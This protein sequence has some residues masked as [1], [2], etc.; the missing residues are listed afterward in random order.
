MEL[1]AL[2]LLYLCVGCAAFFF[3]P[4]GLGGGLLFVP[5]LHYVA[6][7]EIG[8]VT[9][10]T[11]LILTAVVS[12]ASGYRHKKEGLW[13]PELTKSAL[14][15]AIPGAIIGAIIVS[16]IGDNLDLA[17]KL[18]SLL[19]IGYAIKRMRKRLKPNE[20]LDDNETELNN[21]MIGLGSSIGG[22]TSAFLAVGGG[23][24]YIPVLDKFSNASTREIVGS[25]YGIM[26]WTV[27]IVILT[28]ALLFSGPWHD[29]G[30][31]LTL[32]IIVFAMANFG[33]KFGL[34]LSD[35]TVIKVFLSI[36]LIVFI[37]YVIDLTSYLN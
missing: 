14:I 25:S 23:A 11:S 24:I 20:N 35:T 36:I 19:M 6:G 27:P 31:I 13:N 26:M 7:W 17:F 33:A 16:L 8:Q 3:A 18:V 12:W 32:P 22:M 37:R 2:V 15:G 10:L 30:V 34:K 21:S 28:H 1:T 9:L 5:I 29:I 4:L